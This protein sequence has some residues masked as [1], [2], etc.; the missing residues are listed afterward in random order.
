MSKEMKNGK[1][2]YLTITCVCIDLRKLKL[3][4]KWKNESLHFADFILGSEKCFF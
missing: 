4:E 3:V 1:F 2:M